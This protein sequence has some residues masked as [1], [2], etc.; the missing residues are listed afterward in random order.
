[1]ST[2]SSCFADDRASIPGRDVAIVR[3]SACRVQIFRGSSVQSDVLNRQLTMQNVS[4]CPGDSTFIYFTEGKRSW[5]LDVE[6]GLG[7]GL[8]EHDA[9]LLRLGFPFVCGH[10]PGD[11]QVSSCSCFYF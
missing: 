11:I 2:M 5:D 8:D 4:A 7:A 1:M 9:V 10:L 6:A 3:N